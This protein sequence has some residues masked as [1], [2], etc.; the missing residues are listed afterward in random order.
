MIQTMSN[1]TFEQDGAVGIITLANPPLNLFSMKLID[2][3]AAAIATAEASPIRALLLRADGE[4]FTAGAQVDDVFQGLSAAQAEERLRGFQTMMQRTERLP[5]PTLA[6]VRGLC[7]AA[8]LE[9]VLAVDLIWASETAMFA[10][11]EPVIGLT[12]PA[13]GVFRL[14]ARA[15]AGR[16]VESVLTGRPYPAATMAD[17]G[18]VNRVLADD[19]LDE[20]SLAFARKL[21]E[22]PTRAYDATKQMLLTYRNEGAAA[23]EAMTPQVCAQ[24][25]ETEDM[26]HGIESLLANGPGQ[27]TFHGR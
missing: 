8:G 27:A 4:H 25:F 12:P 10:F 14:A 11:A 15:G 2:E 21:A 19:D 16:A 5:F 3:F 17:W 26:I 13:G 22:G 9:T 6:A 23:A 1:V 20:K 7:L 24:L 18:V